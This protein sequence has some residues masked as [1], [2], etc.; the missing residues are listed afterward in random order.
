MSDNEEN[1]ILLKDARIIAAR[2]GWSFSELV[3]ASL[4]EYVQRHS[5]GNH[6]LTLLKLNY[7]VPR[8]EQRFATCKNS[9]KMPNKNDVYCLLINTWVPC[10]R[11]TNC[12]DY[13]VDASLN[14]R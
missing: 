7:R 6:Q 13:R 3:A 2:E 5:P 9:N 10:S 11:C 1:A 14:Q 12:I 8:D 4:K